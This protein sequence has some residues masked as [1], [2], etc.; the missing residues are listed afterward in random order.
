MLSLENA[1]PPVAPIVLAI[2]TGLMAAWHYADVHPL[3]SALGVPF[4]LTLTPLRVALLAWVV[5]TVWCTVDGPPAHRGVVLLLM[6][7]LGAAWAT[8]EELMLSLMF[9]GG[10]RGGGRAVVLGRH[11]GPP[12]RR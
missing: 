5:V 4:H 11:R 2:V 12:R 6:A 7:L 8:Q 9:G 1:N 10:R 3:V